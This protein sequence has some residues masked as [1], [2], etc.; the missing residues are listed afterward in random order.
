M[1]WY[2]NWESGDNPPYSL[3]NLSWSQY[4]RV[5]YSFLVPASDQTI[6]VTS[7]DNSSLH[8]FVGS[9]RENNVSS[10]VTIGGW[11]GST[12]FSSAVAAAENRTRFV[13]STVA[14]VNNYGLDGI[15]FDWEYPSAIGIGCNQR[16][17]NDTANY[18]L[19]LQELRERLPNKTI[20]AAVALT[21]FVNGSAGEP[22]TDVSVFASVLDYIEIM[23]Y[24]VWTASSASVG[25]N[26]PLYDS[27]ASAEDRQG[28]AASA[29]SAW[30]VAGFQPEQIVLGVAGYG[31]SYRVATDDA[32]YDTENKILQLYAPFNW[33]DQPRGDSWDVGESTTDQCGNPQNAYTGIFSFWGLVQQNYLNSTGLPAHG[34]EYGWDSCS[35]TPLIYNPSEQVMISYD[36]VMSFMR[37]GFYIAEERLRGW[38]M[39][40]A[41]NDW[42]DMLTT[43]M[44]KAM[45]SSY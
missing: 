30:T 14:L 35:E 8:E 11:D 28:S 9:A 25:P 6:T 12:Y 5:S 13:N 2:A 43:S 18:L 31:H 33:Q 40:E 20:S 4:T 38:A 16:S 42:N 26:S 36:D 27:C 15:D 1:T 37:K 29:V 34:I 41:S 10:S 17:E 45:M 24:D 3:T 21:P 44:T 7:A 22:S 23:V 39:W 32:Y 19:F